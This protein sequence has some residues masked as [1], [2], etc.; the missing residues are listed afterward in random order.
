MS[1][2]DGEP[3]TIAPEMLEY[4]LQVNS[5]WDDDLDFILVTLKGFDLESVFIF[6][7]IKSLY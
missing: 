4:S 5:F 6:F 1:N 3:V 7:L 2:V